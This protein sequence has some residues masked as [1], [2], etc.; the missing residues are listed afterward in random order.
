MTLECEFCFGN[1]A[2]ERLSSDTAGHSDL[3]RCRGKTQSSFRQLLASEEPQ[4]QDGVNMT[5]AS[6]WTRVRYTFSVLCCFLAITLPSVLAQTSS[7]ADPGWPRELDAR[8]FHIVVYQPQV[9]QWKKNHL[10]ARAAVTV[11][12]PGEPTAQYGIVSLTARTDV[13][14]ESRMVTLEDLKVSSVSFPAAKSQES[15][16]ERA[17]RD[18]LPDWPRTITLDRLLAELAMTQAEVDNESVVVKNDPPKILV[19]LHSGGADFDRRAAGSA[20]RAGH[21]LPTRDQHAGDA[22]L[23]YFRLALLSRR[24]WRLGD[25]IHGIHPGRALG[26]PRRT[27]RPDL[28]RPKRRSSKAKRKTRTITPRMPARH[29]EWISSG[30]IREHHAGGIARNP[31]RAP[32]LAYSQ[33]QVALRHQY[34]EQ[35]LPGRSHT[36]LLRAALRDGGTRARR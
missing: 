18:G 35:H 4:L 17:I 25:G 32:A 28:M 14:K 20:K 34:R 33:N 5:K 15:E 26:R 8:G 9:D 23:R 24:Q 1:W 29:P 6:G 19:Q 31:R 21:S 10:E 30:G 12:R 11:T 27:R 22:D 2:G 13:D 7:D 3:P 36:E 16:L